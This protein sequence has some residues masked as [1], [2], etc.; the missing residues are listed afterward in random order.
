MKTFLLW[1]LIASAACAQSPAFDVA[2]IKPNRSG[3]G[4]SSIR[5]SNGLIT[6][7][8]AS[9]KKIIFA[10]YG[11][12][13]DRDYMLNGPD[14]LTSEQFDIQA[15]FPAGTPPPQMQQMMQALLAERF[16]LTQHRET[17]QISAYAL[18]VAKDGPKIHA[19]DAG[20]PYSSSRPGQ[21]EA[22]KIPMQKLADL[23]GRLIE[24]PVTDA[25]GLPGVFDITLHWWP[26]RPTAPGDAGIDEA[27][28]PSIFTALQEQLG[29]KLESRKEPVAIFVIDHIDK[30][31]T[32]N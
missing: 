29:L 32:G 26:D 19:V 28:A 23:L 16:K 15:R 25:T 27:D 21:L 7:E 11:I 22:K 13:E 20:Q 10:A 6:I 1:F 14:W 30:L 12:P 2:S 31:P 24:Q 17:R 5:A 18:V 9:L 8:N 3:T 4:V